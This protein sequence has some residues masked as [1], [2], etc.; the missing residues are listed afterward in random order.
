MQL[1]L[2]ISVRYRSRRY[3]RRLATLVVPFW[4]GLHL[5]ISFETCMRDFTVKEPSIS[6]RDFDAVWNSPRRSKW[7]TPDLVTLKCRSSSK[8]SLIFEMEKAVKGGYRRTFIC[9]ELFEEARRHSSVE[10][11]Y[12]SRCASKWSGA[13][14]N[15]YRSCNLHKLVKR[16][17]R[18]RFTWWWSSTSHRIWRNCW[19]SQAIDSRPE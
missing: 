6:E 13:K 16:R 3:Q 9:R 7:T 5:D 10:S 12:G 4:A 19:C 1:R 11:L 17:A 15:G 14:C 18:Y 2:Q 8:W